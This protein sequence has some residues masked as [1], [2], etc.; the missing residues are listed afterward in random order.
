[1]RRVIRADSSFAGA[2]VEPG[3]HTRLSGYRKPMF[4][5]SPLSLASVRY[6]VRF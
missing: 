1:M 6:R 4:R 3:P 5:I 2:P